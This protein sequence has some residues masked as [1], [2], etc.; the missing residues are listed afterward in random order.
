[1][2]RA[3]RCGCKSCK[4]WHR[5]TK[6]KIVAVVPSFN[7]LQMIQR[8]VASLR[9]QT[10]QP[11]AILIVDGSTLPEMRAWLEAQSDVTK[12]YVENRGSAGGINVG[13]RWGVAHDFDWLWLLDDDVVALPDAL[14][15]LTDVLTRRP[16]IFV[17]NSLCVQAEDATRA[18]AG[19]VIWR[20]DPQNYLSGVF[21][22]TVNEI[23]AR[24]DADGLIDTLGGQLY[25]GTL[26]SVRVVREIGAPCPEFFTR[27]DEVEYGLRMMRAGYHT[28]ICVNSIVT[29]P[30][31]N[32]LFVT[33]FGKTLMFGRMTTQKRYY[34]IRNS[35]WIRRLYFPHAQFWLYVLKR[36]AAGIFQELFVD[37]AK[38]PRARLY[39]CGQVLR[40]VRDGLDVPIGIAEPL[41]AVK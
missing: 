10:R 32:T 35:I 14:E 26:L 15:R 39:G 40:A 11:D 27:G 37:R 9:A 41:I 30:S 33:L 24:A 22:Q 12:V 3:R 17:I 23:R 2:T 25:Q 19:A 1:M 29:H 8:C 7:R 20:N 31:S 28:Y 18:A 13:M 38:S 16:D 21:L 5:D 34:S 4:T 36:G 6:L